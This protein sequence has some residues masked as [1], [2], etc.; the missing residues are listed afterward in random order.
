MESALYDQDFYLWLTQT[1]QFLKTGE[2][3]QLDLPN[4]IEEIEDM[5]KSQKK[6]IKSN[7]RVILWHLLKYQYQPEKRTKSWRLTIYKHRDRLQDSFAESPSLKNFFQ[8]VFDECYQK[9]RETASQETELLIT[10]FPKICPFSQ[11]ET[12]DKNY[13]PD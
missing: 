11:E 3:H 6:A 9:A 8:E 13:L 5:G 7:L 10:V 12:L 4:L 1:S 2:F